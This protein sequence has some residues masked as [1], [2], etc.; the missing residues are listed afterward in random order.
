MKV[1]VLVVTVVLAAAFLLSCTT[2][3]GTNGGSQVTKWAFDWALQIARNWAEDH[4]G[5]WESDA[6]IYIYQCIWADE[7]C[8]LGRPQADSFWRIAFQNAD[9]VPYSVTVD[10]DGDADGDPLDDPGFEYDEIEAYSNSKLEEMMQFALYETDYFW[11]LY[12]VAPEDFSWAVEV[13]TDWWGEF[14]D[15]ENMFFV[16]LF[17]KR[18]DDFAWSFIVLDADGSGDD[19][20]WWF[21]IPYGNET[22]F[23]TT[24]P[25]SLGR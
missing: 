19:Y 1:K 7:K 12:G 20:D 22:R 21:L 17:E 5:G 8:M 4:W 16:F 25:A 2:T 24:G 10:A 18:S 11:E 9:D 15:A 14:S 3:T 13:R 23:T 6:H